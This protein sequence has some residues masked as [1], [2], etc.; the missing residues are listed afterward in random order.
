MC[1]TQR[2]AFREK[3]GA[4]ISTNLKDFQNSEGNVH[5][6]VMG[7]HTLSQI[8][9]K[10]LMFKHFHN[11]TKYVQQYKQNLYANFSTTP[12]RQFDNKIESI[13]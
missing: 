4:I 8:Q 12:Y 1:H 9:A 7:D 11:L 6:L 13:K 5:C 10:N 3:T 2:Q